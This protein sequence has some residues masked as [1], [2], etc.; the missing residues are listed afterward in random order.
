MVRRFQQKAI[1]VKTV[2]AVF[3]AL[4]F[5]LLLSAVGAAFYYT[6]LPHWGYFVGAAALCA[7]LSVI[8]FRK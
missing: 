7:V 8:L 3:G 1:K 2:S 5:L 4:F 6:E